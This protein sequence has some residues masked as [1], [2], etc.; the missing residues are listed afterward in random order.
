[1][2]QQTGALVVVV[3]DYRILGCHPVISG[4]FLELVPGHPP[5]R[6]PHVY[7]HQNSEGNLSQRAENMTTKHF[8][9]AT[10]HA[11]DPNA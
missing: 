8:R 3:G 9:P 7:T 4:D 11:L 2:P 10:P 1:M 6:T 5:K